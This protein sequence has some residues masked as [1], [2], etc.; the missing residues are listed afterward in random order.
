MELYSAI[1]L[2]SNNSHVGI[3]DA[4]QRSHPSCSRRDL[5]RSIEKTGPVLPQKASE[6]IPISC[7]LFFLTYNSVFCYIQAILWGVFIT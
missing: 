3:M 2:H 1:D 4:Q 5:Q 6:K 7:G